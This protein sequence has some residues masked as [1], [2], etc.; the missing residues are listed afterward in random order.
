V[1]IKSTWE[2]VRERIKIA[3]QEDLGYYELE[4]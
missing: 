3:D 2:N 4:T 1:D